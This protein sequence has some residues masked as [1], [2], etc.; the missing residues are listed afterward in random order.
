MLSALVA[1]RDLCVE[2][3]A[4]A[5]SE[6][7]EGRASPA[8]VGAFL[9]ALAT[10]GETPEEIA[11]ML[12]VVRDA[13]VRVELPPSLAGGAIDIVGT[14]G[15][16]SGS[17]NISTMAAFVV[18]G[19]GVPVCKHGNRAASSACGTADV[20][21]ELGMEIELGPD[22]VVACIEESGFG[23]CF[24]PRFHPAFRHVG[25]ARREMG[26]P[27]VFN[28]LGPMANPAGVRFM[29]VGVSRPE[30]LE[31]V[32][33]A[34][35]ASG[36]RSAWVVHGDAGGA[37]LDELGLGGPNVVMEVSG[38]RVTSK[39]VDGR[40]LGLGP[41]TLADLEGG[42]ATRNAT[43]V[44]ETLGGMPGAVREVVILN[45]GAALV[46]AG[47]ADDLG[48]GVELAAAS[49]DSGRAGQA[50]EAAI[51]ASRGGRQP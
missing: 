47:A 51:A 44:R 36:V 32:A 3:C 15:D 35:A 25:P 1:R 22:D 33:R 21:A 38:D 40:E 18:A 12:A 17:V 50:M 42:D 39:V 16:A 14:G 4:W 28:L 2:D 20:L 7:L 27:T 11:A 31:T 48:R 49:I 8:Q 24:A 10:K 9:G 19:A 26:I 37:P 13:A 34:L 41:W 29:L 5:M 30:S 45:A 6:M 46:V 23:F 43:V